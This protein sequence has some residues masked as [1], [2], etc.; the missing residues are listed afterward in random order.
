MNY[1]THEQTS[2]QKGQQKEEVS[3]T[4][5][6]RAVRGEERS[7]ISEISLQ[8]SSSFSLEGRRSR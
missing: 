3:V 5:K 6:R 8:Q 1:T 4:K 2:H 7:I